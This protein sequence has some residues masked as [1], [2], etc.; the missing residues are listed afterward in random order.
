MPL[1]S[2]PPSRSV[3]GASR[4][5]A[6]DHAAAAAP[7][8]PSMHERPPARP[9]GARRLQTICAGWAGAA[10]PAMMARGTRML[11]NAARDAQYTGAGALHEGRWRGQGCEEPARAWHRPNVPPAQPVAHSSPGRGAASAAPGLRAATAAGRTA[12]SPLQA[13]V[14]SGPRSPNLLCKPQ[15]SP[16]NTAGQQAPALHAPGPAPAGSLTT[17]A[18]SQTLRDLGCRAW[19]MPGTKQ[20][21]TIID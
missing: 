1:S 21:D 18:V 17:H 2:A 10:N 15:A 9:R 8:P 5:A 7:P 16:G 12:H 6:P 13:P 4:G 20:G 11:G 14:A 3:C 19:C